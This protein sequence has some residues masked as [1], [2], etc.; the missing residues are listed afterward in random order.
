MCMSHT[1][2]S[3][4]GLVQDRLPKPENTLASGTFHR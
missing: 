3:T 4:Q 1:K 2:V